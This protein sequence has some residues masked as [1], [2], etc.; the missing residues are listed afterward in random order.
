M[1][2][3]ELKEYLW[4]LNDEKK[5]ELIQHLLDSMMVP[6]GICELDGFFLIDEETFKEIKQ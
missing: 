3:N 2:E 5:W 6:N 4:N 1:E